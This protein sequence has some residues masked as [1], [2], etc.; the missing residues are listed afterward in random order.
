MSAVAPRT[1]PARL[2]D[3]VRL[4]E[5]LDEERDDLI[6]RLKEESQRAAVDEAR[7]K[8]V[9]ALVLDDLA[10]MKVP[11]TRPKT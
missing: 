2:V 7:R 9:R 6:D 1:P 11:K 10:E 5:A 4:L 3:E 8:P